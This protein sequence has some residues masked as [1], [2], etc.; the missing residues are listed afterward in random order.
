MAFP[1]MPKATA[2]WLVENTTLTFDQIAEF[3]GLH[4]LEV[5]AIADGEVG[6]N[7]VGINPIIKGQLTQAEIDRCQKDTKAKLKLLTAEVPVKKRA[8]G[9]RYTPVAKRQDKPDGI[10]WLVKHHPELSDTQI[11]KLIG[12]TK[13]TIA[14][15]RDRSHWNS[16]NIKAR[17]PILLGICNPIELEESIQRAR[18]RIEGDPNAQIPVAAAE[19]E[20]A[21]PDAA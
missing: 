13:P 7:I 8:K 19:Y 14:A 10:A 2:V 21:E 9:P 5:T 20:D 6:Q 11:S 4:V 1:L 3:C 16:A 15:I 17:N 12:T 18:K